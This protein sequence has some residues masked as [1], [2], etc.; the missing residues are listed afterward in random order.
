VT[1]Y[2]GRPVLHDP[3]WKDEIAWYLFSGGLAGASSVL[4]AGAR[5][6][7]RPDL[8][9][10]ARRVALGGA[11][12]SPVLLISDLGRPSRFANMLRVVRPTSP[13][14]MGSW[15]LSVYGPS[16][17]AAAVLDAAGVLPR[18][19]RMADVSA[20]VT[21]TLLTTYTGVL[22]ADTSVPV[23]H[24]AHR[25][26][27]FVFAASAAT[28]AGAAAT[29]FARPADA[30]PARRLAL[31]GLV[32]EQLAMRTM[33]LRLRRLSPPGTGAH[34]LSPG[35]DL[36]G[37][38][39]RTGAAGR[40]HRTAGWLGRVGGLTLAAARWV[41]GGARPRRAATVAGAGL[42]L[43]SAAATRFAIFRAGSQSANDPAATIA[44]QRA[45]RE[46]RERERQPERQQVRPA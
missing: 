45:R 1:S 44:P 12:A 6:T 43:A 17:G 34:P 4:A 39:Y 35:A 37:A 3:V 41:P 22:L 18:L 2:Y 9:R 8:A 10:V 40:Y 19:A 21:G 28:S 36:L 5:L 25:E 26:L 14:N 16:A 24:E 27:P 29:L 33:E 30:G 46:E 20:A 11:L 32:A 42:L 31:G 7:G 23:W 38:P 13:M 15:L